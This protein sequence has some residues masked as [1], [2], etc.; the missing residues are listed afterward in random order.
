MTDFLSLKK[1]QKTD[2]SLK[3]PLSQKHQKPLHMQTQQA[4]A[5]AFWSLAILWDFVIQ[6]WLNTRQ[7]R[8][9]ES[10]TKHS[11]YFDRQTLD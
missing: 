11:V 10:L 8:M 7:D 5:A 9:S 4:G 3:L 6:D 1:K 2:Q